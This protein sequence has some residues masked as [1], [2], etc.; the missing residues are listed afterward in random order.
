MFRNKLLELLI[1]NV[2]RFTRGQT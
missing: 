1:Q 2:P